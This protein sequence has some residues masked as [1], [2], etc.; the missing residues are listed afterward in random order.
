MYCDE[1]GEIQK[2]FPN[3]PYC[4]EGTG[5]LQAV[6]KAAQPVS[7]CQTVLPGN[8]AMIIPT[9]VEEVSTLAVPG[10]SYWCETAAQYY[11]NAPGV[12]V[13]E[14]CVWGTN[15]KP[16]GNWS[17][18]TAGGNTAADGTTYMKIG[19]NPIY[20]EPTTP[21]RNVRPNFGIS[22]ECDGEGCNGLPCKIDP[23]SM[24]VNVMDALDVFTGAGGAT[25]CVVTVPPGRKGSIIVFDVDG[26]GSSS[27]DSSPQSNPVSSIPTSSS[28][29]TSTP[30]P[31]PTSS[32]T[33]TA[34]PTP[35]ESPEETSN[36]TP[37]STSTPTPTPSSESS[38]SS[39]S[40]HTSTSTEAVI[41]T[42][43]G[44]P[45]SIMLPKSSP[46]MSYTYRPHVFAPSGAAQISSEATAIA[47]SA[48]SATAAT[49]AATSTT[50]SMMS[51]VFGAI[52]ALA[53]NY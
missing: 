52:A 44:A 32:S 45:S 37:S 12:S 10:T 30:T 20:L 41:P 14:G 17:P 33:S 48:S 3:K 24:D 1:N 25:G 50:V 13:E 18:Y 5:A 39:T 51:V 4:Q 8:E 40:T 35:T 49:G 47:A 19:W 42:L 22:I 6:N 31:L 2:P 7:F 9:L 43:T 16:V 29:S 26:S 28:T 38:S 21:F 23:S 11:I 36:P 15:A 53:M 27:G 46:S 34:T